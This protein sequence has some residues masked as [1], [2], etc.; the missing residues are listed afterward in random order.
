MDTACTGWHLTLLGTSPHG[1]ARVTSHITQGEWGHAP[2]VAA[3]SNCMCSKL[4][5]SRHGHER[6][7]DGLIVINPTI[8]TDSC[9]RFQTGSHSPLT[10]PASQ[11]SVSESRGM[12]QRVTMHGGSQRHR[13]RGCPTAR[14]RCWVRWMSMLRNNTEASSLP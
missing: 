8:T 10:K 11:C 6:M 7:S 9:A 14:R 1:V 13:I 5:H 4:G 2:Q 3:G 12:A